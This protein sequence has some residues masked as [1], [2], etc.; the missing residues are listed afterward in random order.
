M[1]KVLLLSGSPRKG[2]TDFVLSKI[3]E[4]INEDNEIVFLRDKEI[5]H[6]IGCMSCHEKPECVIKDEM[7]EI[8]R[9]MLESEIIIIDI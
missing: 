7:I 9:M 6:C 8:G 1:A 2:N 5:K 3:S 4:S